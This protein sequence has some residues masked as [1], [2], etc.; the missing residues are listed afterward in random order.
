MYIL[1]CG[2]GQYYTGSTIDLDRRLEQHQ[3]GEGAILPENIFRLNLS[4]V[5]PSTGL[6]RPSTGKSKF[7]NGLMPRRKL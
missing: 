7:K 5:K 2:N 1:L 3:N 4:I 6:M